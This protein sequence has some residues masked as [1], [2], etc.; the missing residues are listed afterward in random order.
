MSLILGAPDDKDA[1]VLKTSDAHEVR[2]MLPRAWANIP[3]VEFMIGVEY[4]L[5]NT[6]LVP[7]DPR[8]LFLERI[9]AAKVGPGWNAAGQRIHVADRTAYRDLLK[10]APP[11]SR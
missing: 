9:R 5:E 2:V 11:A 6:D 1:A 8:L 10:S 3:I 4:V 7:N